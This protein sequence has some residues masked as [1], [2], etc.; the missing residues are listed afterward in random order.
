[1]RLY[2]P[3]WII[4]RKTIRKDK[5][6]EYE[7]REKQNILICPYVLHRNEQ[8]WENPEAFIPERFLPEVSKKRVK[9]TYLPFGGGP[10]MCI[11]YNFA[12]MEMLVVLSM[13]LQRFKVESVPGKEAKPEA[14]I[15][16]RPEK[17]VWVKISQA[18]FN[19]TTNLQQPL[20]SSVPHN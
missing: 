8:Y 18:R 19:Q 7:L 11:G 3:A 15:T 17:G 2:P 10:R 14:L 12:M 9:N 4:G 16:L 1:M 13:I 6:G 5:L 20:T